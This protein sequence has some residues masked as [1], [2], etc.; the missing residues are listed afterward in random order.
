M[1]VSAG[2]D[3]PGIGVEAPGAQGIQVGEGNQ[4]FN[5][6]IQNYID[7]RR[8]SPSPV[9]GPMVIGEVPQV[10]PAFQPREGLVAS[11]ESYGPGEPVAQAVIGMRG[12]GKT[13]VAAA[14]A[15]SRIDAGWRLVA[16][17][18]AGDTVQVLNGL[19]GVAA[20]LVSFAI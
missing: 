7:Q 12:V 14:Y 4:Q 18:N 2:S 10:P 19:A 11:L 8:V 13:Q 17:V 20:S 1:T 6:F 3:E 16:W 15:R 9:T 5:Q